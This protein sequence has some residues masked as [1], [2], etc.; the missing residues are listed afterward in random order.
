MDANENGPSETFAFRPQLREETYRPFVTYLIALAC[1]GVYVAMGLAGVSLMEPTI[2]A[3]IAWGADFGPYVV[4]DHQEWR[5]FTN[6]FVHIGFIHLALNLWCLLSAAPLVERLFGHAGFAVLYLMAGLGGSI[7]SLGWHPMLVSA[8]ASGAIFGVYGALGA[9]LTVHRHVI[10][11][12]VLAPLRASTLSFVGYNLVFG[13]MNSQIDTAAHL[14]GLVTGFV[15]G[16]MLQ[17]PWPVASGSTALARRI[18]LGGVAA[19]GLWFAYANV[20]G[21]IQKEPAIEGL[22]EANDRARAALGRFLEQVKPE[23]EDY[24][25]IDHDLDMV[26]GQLRQPQPP[27]Q[28]TLTKTLDDLAVRAEADRARLD[29]TSLDDQDLI[30]LR[31]SLS[32]AFASLVPASHALR[33]LIETGDQTHV[34][35]PDGFNHHRN[36]SQDHLKSYGKALQ[37]YAGKHHLKLVGQH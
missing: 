37:D 3:L 18:V 1:I 20:R 24:N 15:A 34:T 4:N 14:G 33:R 32:Q 31:T 17:R 6:L 26:I 7:A 19:V 8:G 35:G 29:R 28:A 12:S 21:T 36:A 9:F 30:A 23:A 13:A 25:R 16:L 27:P 10:P 22:S 5:L 2:A 11:A